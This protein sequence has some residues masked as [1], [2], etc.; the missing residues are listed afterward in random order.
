MC[1]NLVYDRSFQFSRSVVSNSSATPWTA[2]HQAS[3]SNTNSWSL[4]KLISIKL[5]MPSNHLILCC[6]LLFLPS[7]FPSIRSQFLASGGQSIGV[8]AQHQSSNE[9]SG[10]ISFRI[11]WFDLLAVQ[12]T[13]KSLRH[14][15]SKAS[16]S[17]AFQKMDSAY[18]LNK[19][20]D[21]IWPDVILSQFGTSLLFHMGDQNLFRK[22][23]LVYG[24]T[25]K[26]HIIWTIIM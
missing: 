15:N 24:Y 13:L 14:H 7:I 21:N 16:S 3:L 17:P 11:Y 18:T 26:V 12:K 8:S 22:E 2:A 4:L 6:P 20:D 10:L 1:E 25:E 19:Q 23:L 5:V 9:Y